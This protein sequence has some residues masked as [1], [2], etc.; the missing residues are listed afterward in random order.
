MLGTP[1]L[2]PATPITE[3]CPELAEGLNGHVERAQRI[4]T[5]S[6]A[7]GYELYDG[8]V[9]LGPLNRDVQN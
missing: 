6:A 3:A 8:N 1:P 5:E 4:H 9:V 7:G 2:C